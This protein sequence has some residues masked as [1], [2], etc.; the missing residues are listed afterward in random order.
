MRDAQSTNLPTFAIGDAIS[1]RT[2][3]LNKERV[4]WYTIGMTSSATGVLQPVQHNIHTSDEHARSQGLPA[5]I[6]DGMHSTN[7]LSSMLLEHFHEHYLA[8]GALRTKFI[9][10]T[11]VGTVL[12]PRGVISSR[13]VEPDGAV[14]YGLDVWIEDADGTKLTVGDAAVVVSGGAL[15]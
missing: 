11:F 5:A 4:S 12:T 8:R 3:P 2:R 1:A 15:E 10:P 13:T 9:K 7:W 14:R 6:S